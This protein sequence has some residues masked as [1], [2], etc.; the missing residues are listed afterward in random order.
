MTRQSSRIPV[1]AKGIVFD[2]ERVWLRRNERAEWELPGGKLDPGEQPT[3]TIVRELREELGLAVDVRQIVQA[4]RYAVADSIDEHSGVLVV[5]YLCTPGVRVGDQEL[6]GE[7]GEAE[8]RLFTLSEVTEAIMPS[9][10]KE[11]I[12]FAA[13]LQNGAG[14][15]SGR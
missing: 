5:S 7:A 6:D 14:S 11:A 9:F 12:F 15:G 13:D 8:F 2:G 10:Y 3:E 4:H 1:S